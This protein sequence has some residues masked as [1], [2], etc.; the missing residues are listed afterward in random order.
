MADATSEIEQLREALR[1][2]LYLYH[3]LD[4]PEIADA[5]YDLLYRRL[6]ELEADNPELVAPDSPTQRVGQAASELFAPVKHRERLFSL[7]NVESTEA[8]TAWEERLERQLGEKPSGYMCE[9]KID[10]LAVSL[11]YTDGSLTKAATRGDGTTGEDIT[12]NVRTIGAVPLVLRGEAPSVMEVRG[13]IY[14]PLPEFERLNKDQ[15]ASGQALYANAR[16]TAAG[17]VRQKDPAVTAS[18]RLSIWVYQ[19]GFIEGGPKLTRHSEIAAWLRQLGFLFNPAS[20]AV[21]DLKGV[22]DYVNAAE[23][24]RHARGYETDGVVIK[25]DVLAEQREA[26]FTAKSPR[27]AVAYKFPPEER[28]TVLADI[29][30]NVGRTGA[31]TPYAVLEPVFVGGVTVTTATLHNADEVARKDLRVGDTVTVRRAGDVIPE[32][33][34]PVLALRKGRPRRWKMPETCPFSGHPIVRDGAVAYCTGGFDC[35]GR[36]RE[37]LAH[38][39]GRDGMDIEG[40]GYKTV[41]LLLTE[42]LISDPADLFTLRAD[43]LLG[44]EGWGEVSSG[45]LIGAIAAAKDRPLDRL[46]RALG[47]PLVGGTVASTLARRFRSMDKIMSST[48]D[49][50]DAIDG[51]G[52]ELVASVQDWVGDAENRALVAKLERAGVRTEDPEPEGVDSTVLAGVTIVLTGTMR[53]MSREEA[54]NAVEDRGGK[55]TSSVSSKTTAV[56]VGESPG[57]KATKAEELG[58]PILDEE[59][60]LDL[61]EN[62]PGELLE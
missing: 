23:K 10:G 36:L 48:E 56:V 4:K 31:A 6:E 15:E 26:G 13:E 47:I 21:A 40:L 42:K 25:A 22:I 50:L 27:W 38:F 3:V 52:P 32:V 35:P 16:N 44:R 30:I 51:I 14:M 33:V 53:S 46:L 62:G 61:L 60:F 59:A 2:H 55:V 57:S 24:A 28:T 9:L 20:E 12:A 19:V 41:D 11:T 58:R 37:Y 1:H 5:E 49:E 29:R 54:G 45:N 39:A 7:D 8:L 34:G 18:R 43:D 17:S